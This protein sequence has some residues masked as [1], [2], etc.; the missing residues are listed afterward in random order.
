MRLHVGGGDNDNASMEEGFECR[1][2]VDEVD[3]RLEIP[4]RPESMHSVFFA[5]FHQLL[6]PFVIGSDED[7]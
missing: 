1:G 5:S 4:E 3:L 2:V 7:N 6:V